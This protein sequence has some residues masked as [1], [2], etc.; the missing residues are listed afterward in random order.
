[1]FYENIADFLTCN[2]YK[3]LFCIFDFVLFRPSVP[4]A[5]TTVDEGPRGGSMG[6]G[7]KTTS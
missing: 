5:E 3:F 7:G 2:N 6:N 4:S 1:M